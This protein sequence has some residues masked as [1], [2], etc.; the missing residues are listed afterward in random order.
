[1][2]GILLDTCL[3]KFPVLYFIIFSVFFLRPRIFSYKT[4]IE[5]LNSGH[6]L[7]ILHHELI[8][9][10]YYTIEFLYSTLQEFYSYF[11]KQSNSYFS[12]I[13]TQICQSLLLF[14]SIFNQCFRVVKY[15]AAC[16]VTRHALPP[17]SINLYSLKFK[18]HI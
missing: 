1:M 17:K 7:F 2:T 9:S 12:F 8:F 10:P 13:K 3:Y 4:T 18:A 15:L 16:R 5:V 6:L 14:K 11:P